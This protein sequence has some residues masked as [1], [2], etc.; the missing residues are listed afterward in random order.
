MKNKSLIKALWF[1]RVTLVLYFTLKTIK[2][3]I[4]R[5]HSI[6]MVS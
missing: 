6:N 3:Y 5:L 1:S 2:Y 4:M